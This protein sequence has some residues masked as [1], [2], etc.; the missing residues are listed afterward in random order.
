MNTAANVLR[1]LIIVLIGLVVVAILLMAAMVLI[2]SFALFGVKFVSYTG[3]SGDP[4]RKIDIIKDHE[5]EWATTK[6]LVIETNGWGVEFRPYSNVGDSNYHI[7]GQDNLRIL[8]YAQY[9][10][11]VKVG[12]DGEER[13]TCPNPV[14]GN[15]LDSGGAKAC[16]ISPKEPDAVWI[17]KSSAKIVVLYDE[18]A[19]S[20]IDDIYIKTDS[21]SIY[22][23]STN[24]S[25][26]VRGDLDKK[27]TIVSKSGNITVGNIDVSNSLKITKDSGDLNIKTNMTGN[28]TLSINAG[29]GTINVKDVGNPNAA[30][31]AK[32]VNFENIRNANIQFGTIYGD[33][34]YMTGNSGLVRGK[35]VTGSLIV[36]KTDS[37]TFKITEIGQDVNFNSDSGSLFAS[38]VGGNISQTNIKGNGQINVRALGGSSEIKSKNGKISLGEAFSGSANTGFVGVKGNVDIE[39]DSADIYVKCADNVKLDLKSKNGYVKLENVMGTVNYSVVDGGKSGIKATYRELSG[40]NTFTTNSGSVDIYISVPA[41][42]TW[43]SERSTEIEVSNL[44]TT[45][46]TG[47]KAINGA[48]GSSGSLTI[49]TVAGKIKVKEPSTN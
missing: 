27:V 20:N 22:L 6:T 28:M 12:E 5:S 44:R 39:T 14:F 21:G 30:S 46:K 25:E 40:A 9:T 3:S 8:F 47:S 2:P 16:I 10:G 7:S 11:F 31:N 19:L 34:Q 1:I 13:A 26:N 43:Q 41:N 49:T 32:S 24:M 23:G 33:L 15:H 36:N 29:Y 45:E 4:D 48:N 38:Y 42:L 37:C 17:S 18:G 35:K